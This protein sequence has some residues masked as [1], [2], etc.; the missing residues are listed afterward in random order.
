MVV[1]GHGQEGHVAS[2]VTSVAAISGAGVRLRQLLF[3]IQGRQ[4]K[5]VNFFKILH[6]IIRL[7][8]S[9]FSCLE[10]YFNCISVNNWS[11]L[12]SFVR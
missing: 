9:S 3:G 7:S 4:S 5:F 8:S 6:L 1:N 12:R 11:I 2:F 10:S